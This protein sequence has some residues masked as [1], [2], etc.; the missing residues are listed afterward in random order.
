MSDAWKSDKV[1]ILHHNW[2]HKTAKQ[3]AE[4]LGPGFTRSMVLGKARRD[5]LP[6]KKGA[7]AVAIKGAREDA[8]RNS[9]QLCQFPIGNPGDPEYRYCGEAVM[10]PGK[11]YCAT[12]HAVC[13]RGATAKEKRRLANA[14]KVRA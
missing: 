11:P 10:A 8:R 4:I 14:V 7:K 12:H 2:E 5:G 9:D 13:T 3:I 6:P 1:A